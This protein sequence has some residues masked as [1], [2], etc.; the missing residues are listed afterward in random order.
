VPG[1]LPTASGDPTGAW[2][3]GVP[4]DVDLADHVLGLWSSG[5]SGSCPGW[6][7]SVAT[8]D[9]TVRLLEAQD[10]QG[11]N[12]CTDDYNPYSQVVILDRDQVPT[13]DALPVDGE[14]TFAILTDGTPLP[15]TVRCSARSSPPSPR[16]AASRRR[17]Q[18]PGASGPR[19]PD[20]VRSR[21][22]GAVRNRGSLSLHSG[23][24]GTGRRRGRL[25]AAR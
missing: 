7:A 6:L 19:R 4:D 12:G 5:Q 16:E 14:L 11:G 13:Q 20:P 25:Q 17:T 21:R 9:E 3:Y 10:L 2:V 1:D 24:D 23:C 8:D 22:F 18:G 15:G